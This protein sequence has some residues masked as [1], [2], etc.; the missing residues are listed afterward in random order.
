VGGSCEYL[1]TIGVAEIILQ[2][3]ND[4]FLAK[5]TPRFQKHDTQ[6][7]CYLPLIEPLKQAL[8]PNTPLSLRST[9]QEVVPLT[10]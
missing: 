8:A 2:E 4:T 6:S 9:H 3:D 5:F 7:Y 1:N 10:F